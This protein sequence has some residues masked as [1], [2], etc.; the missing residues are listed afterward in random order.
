MNVKETIQSWQKEI[1]QYLEKNY[2]RL[3]LKASGNW[4]KQ[5]ESFYSEEKNRYDFGILGEKYTS[6]IEYG[7][8]ANLNQTPSAI[9]KWVGWAGSTF[10]KQWTKDKG[11]PEI[12][13]YAI[14]Y[15]I[16]RQGWKVPN[17]FNAGGLVSDVITE[18][19]IDTLVDNVFGAKLLEVKTELINTLKNGNN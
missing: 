13:S 14:A 4:T 15:K 3:K 19:R 8:L 11:I 1:I 18:K 10:I 16:A 12:A 5:L 17:R 6:F 9:R 7:R 2:L